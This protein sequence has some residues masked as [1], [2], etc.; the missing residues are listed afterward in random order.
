MPKPCWHSSMALACCHEGPGVP[1]LGCFSLAPGSE[2]LCG[3]MA[4]AY[5]KMK[6]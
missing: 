1:H 4:L 5:V 2:D 3:P 6:P